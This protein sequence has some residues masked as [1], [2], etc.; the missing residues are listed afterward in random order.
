MP[1]TELSRWKPMHRH[2]DTHP[3]HETLSSLGARRC[4]TIIYPG[5]ALTSSDGTSPWTVCSCGTP[6]AALQLPSWRP[7][8]PCTFA[9]LPP[10]C[11][12]HSGRPGAVVDS[13]LA[14]QACSF[15]PHWATGRGHIRVRSLCWVWPRTPHKAV[16]IS[17]LHSPEAG[18]QCVSHGNCQASF[19][20][21]FFRIFIYS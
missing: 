14:W 20:L 1:H 17:K 10:G 6:P 5:S 2:T 9:R 3:P 21:G 7:C 15:L 13:P 12:G 11:R 19:F 16:L 4:P 18:D 8:V